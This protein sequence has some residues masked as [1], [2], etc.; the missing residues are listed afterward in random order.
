[1][2]F[3]FSSLVRESVVSFNLRFATLWRLELAAAAMAV[4]STGFSKK[5]RA[6]RARHSAFTSGVP[7][8]LT[9]RIGS[10]R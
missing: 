3:R 5:A 8:P 4:G 2:V 1:M 6:P 9:T 10:S 7:C